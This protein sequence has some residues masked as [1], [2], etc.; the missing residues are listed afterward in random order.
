MATPSRRRAAPVRARRSHAER[1]AET[2]AKVMAAVVASI[3][4]VGFQRTTAAEIT[5]RAGVSWGAVQHHFGDK[6][7][8]LDAVLA[9]SFERFAQRLAGVELDGLDLD[10]RVAT[11]VDGAWEHFGSPHYRCTFEILLN[12]PG[13]EGDA[14]QGM[15]EAW[16]EVW[17]RFFPAPHLARREVV[18]LQLYAIS[19]LSGLATA[20]ALGGR[21]ARLLDGPLALLC[22]ALVQNLEA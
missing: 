8:I 15:L 6:D 16:N 22:E 4:S 17:T 7:G 20:R 12:H 2:R 13:A 14:W 18:A 1:T 5:R 19:V 9:D 3:A 21:P 10:A 11:F